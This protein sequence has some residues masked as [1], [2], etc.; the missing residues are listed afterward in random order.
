MRGSSKRSVG[1]NRVEVRASG[2]HG[3][4]LFARDRITKGARIIEYAGERLPADEGYARYADT[5]PFYTFIFDLE[6]GRVIDGRD[7]NDARFINHSCD[8]NVEAFIERGRVFIYARRAIAA[9]G[10]LLMDYCFEPDDAG[11]PEVRAGYPCSCGAKCCR[12]T[13]VVDVSKGST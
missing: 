10:E 6:D 9:G 1:E 3:R 12:G 13:M 2:I 11:D 8:P 7:S 4:G 5:K